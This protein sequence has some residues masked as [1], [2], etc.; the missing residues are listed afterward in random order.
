MQK[1]ENKKSG[2]VRQITLTVTESKRLIAKGLAHDPSVL[3]RMK[4]GLIMITCGTSNACVAEEL[5]KI[6]LDCGAFLKGRIQPEGSALLPP[7]PAAA[8]EII[9]QDGRYNPEIK[10]S[11]GLNAMR[12]GDII[13]KGANLVNYRDR[14]AAVCIGHPTG[15]TAGTILP[16]VEK[17]GIRL[18]IPVG[19]EKQTSQDL[20]ALEIESRASHQIN[21]KVPWIKVL[22]GELFTEIEAIRQFANVEVCQIASGGIAGAEGAITLTIK[23]DQDAVACA[24]A[25]VESVRGNTSN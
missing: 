8:E 7:E 19:L 4:A 1:I 9:I 18:I 12:S 23:G 24:L 14:K 5:L 20:D 2:I 13:F 22:P 11:A 16:F 6:R 3:E 17:N 10:I 25:A 15:G 21:N